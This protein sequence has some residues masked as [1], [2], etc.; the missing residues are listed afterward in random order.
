MRFSVVIPCY[1]QGRFLTDCL[2]SLAYQTL[3]PG[4]VIVVDDGSTDVETKEFCA[5]LPRYSY[6]FRLRCLRTANGGLSASRNHGIRQCDGDVILPLDADDKLTPDAIE[7]YASL[8]ASDS[9]VD[10]CYPDILEFGNSD[11]LWNVPPVNRWRLTQANFI[12]CS[13]AIRRRV[14][15][16]GYWYDEAMRGGYE[17]WEFW[18]R[19]CALGPFRAAPLRKPAFYYRRWGYSMLRAVNHDLVISSFRAKHQDQGIWSAEIE[20]RL[21]TR[22]AP[23]H[24]VVCSDQSESLFS[25]HDLVPLLE[26]S[27]DDFLKTDQV[28]RFVWF[29]SFPLEATAHLQLIVNEVARHTPMPVYLFSDSRTGS[30]YLTVLD[31]LAVLATVDGN[32]PVSTFSRRALR[33]TTSGDRQPYVV[34]VG[35]PDETSLRSTEALELLRKRVGGNALP[36]GFREDARVDDQLNYFYPREPSVP[37]PVIRSRS[38]RILAIAMPWLT[39]GGSEFAV[40][41]LLQ[42]GAIRRQFDKII[43][44]TFEKDDHPAHLLF[45]RLADTILHLGLLPGDDESYMAIALELLESWGATDFLIANSRHGY[46]LIPRIRKAGLDIRICAQLHSMECHPL[47]GIATE[48]YP[49]D[50]ASQYAALVD[51][52]ACISD[53]LTSFMIDHL[54]FPHHKIKTVRLGVDQERFR[55]AIPTTR[56][57][58]KRVVWCGRLSPEKDPLLAL[59]VAEHFHCQAPD[60]HFVFVGDGPLVNEFSAQLQLCLARG[61]P[62]EWIKST[63][64]VD[65][66]FR[67]SDCLFM[68]SQWEGIP[69]VVMEALSTGIPVVMCFTNTA[70]REIAVPGQCFE[71]NNRLSMEE[72]CQQ[73]R[74][75]LDAPRFAPD[76]AL[77][78]HRYAQEMIDWLFPSGACARKDYL[79]SVFGVAGSDKTSAKAG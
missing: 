4:E 40:R 27:L 53:R 65:E 54:Y 36:T 11:A 48:G 72:L 39:Y 71:V 38:D 37:S 25:G 32:L 28:S 62:V 34:T 77:S 47:T 18:I 67:E 73:L 6:P 13:S 41:I 15:D 22:E 57:R 49:R 10:I 42:E 69:I 20:Q 79:T 5:R 9:Q 46:N 33:I 3:P 12:V 30:V 55:P 17:D 1:N 78:H 7:E 21:R 61:M 2:E 19:T 26:S 56:D 44:L 8:L 50:L 64:R 29:G 68:T 59:R 51:R 75:A 70:M 23:T 76:H 45:E 16:A 31:R 58:P 35:I 63:S 66:V 14:F 24:R 43:I 74:K 60:V 52:V